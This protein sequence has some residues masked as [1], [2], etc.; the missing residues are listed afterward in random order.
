MQ[1]V[2]KNV[3]SYC[4]AWPA[5]LAKAVDYRPMRLNGIVEDLSPLFI[6]KKG[7]RWCGFICRQDNSTGQGNEEALLLQRHRT[8]HLHCLHPGHFHQ[9]QRQVVHPAFLPLTR[10]DDDDNDLVGF[11]TTVVRVRTNVHV[12]KAN[13]F[14]RDTGKLARLIFRFQRRCLGIFVDGIELF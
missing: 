3:E 10:K 11:D 5:G 9:Q 7:G 2:A 6:E 14:Y 4:R 13:V 8:L 1:A 12:V